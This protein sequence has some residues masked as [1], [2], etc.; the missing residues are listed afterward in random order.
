MARPKSRNRYHRA[1][2]TTETEPSEAGLAA[3][4]RG[5]RSHRPRQPRDQRARRRAEARIES[6]RAASRSSPTRPGRHWAFPRAPPGWPGASVSGPRP[7]A[8]RSRLPRT[9]ASPSSATP[10]RSST[11][12][13]PTSSTAPERSARA[14]SWSSSV[15]N[16]S[17]INRPIPP[18]ASAASCVTARRSP[19][20][21]PGCWPA[22]AARSRSPSAMVELDLDFGELLAERTLEAGLRRAILVLEQY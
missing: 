21:S 16:S 6:E 17:S 9:P 10:T 5:R 3:R 2:P 22:A 12:P 8:S 11:S 19:W 15:P 13:A 1:C 18:E 14:T 4:V 20:L 7:P